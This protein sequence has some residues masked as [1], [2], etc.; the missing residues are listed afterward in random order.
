MM[1]IAMIGLGRWGTRIGES[2]KQSDKVRVVRGVDIDRDACATFGAAHGV[3]TSGRFEDA[4]EDDDVQAVIIVTPP[5][6]HADQVLQAVAAGKQVYCEKPLAL[7]RADAER[8]VAACE[9]KG[10]VLGID[11]ERR[12]EPGWEELQRMVKE[13]ELGKI[14]H[15]EANHSHSW[16]GDLPEGTWRGL[17]TEGPSSGYTGMGIH[18]MDL[19]VSLLGLPEDVSAFREDRVIGFA[20]GDVA[21]VQFR[22]ADGTTGTI[23]AIAATP[24]Y[25]RVAIFGEL[26]WV[27]IRE[28]VEAMG[29]RR[30]DMETSDR[31]EVAQTRTYEPVDTVKLAL[32]AW[33]DSVENGTPYRYQPEE[34]I[35]N[36]AMV[37]AITKSMET[38]ERV[39][40]G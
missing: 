21:S 30:S 4:L 28:R 18:F 15:V 2:I 33:V 36:V 14:L 31:S 9:E 7:T 19:F 1:N 29:I 6:G 39:K 38:G 23:A 24:T 5:S 37:E 17:K 27:E 40:V 11:H 34:L 10:I 25:I 20:S 12:F 22:Y 26:G 13:G 8:M 32:E 35:N 3:P 16:M